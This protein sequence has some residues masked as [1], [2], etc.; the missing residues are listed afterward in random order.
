MSEAA[1]GFD[2]TRALAGQ[3]EERKREGERK[4]ASQQERGWREGEE[5]EGGEKENGAMMTI[6]NG[7]AL[8]I[9]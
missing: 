4:M 7:L 8:Q 6:V 9:G 2:E 5:E 1:A 3:G